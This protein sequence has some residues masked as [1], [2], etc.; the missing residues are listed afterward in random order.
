MTT[1]AGL[2]VIIYHELMKWLFTNIIIIEDEEAS[3]INIIETDWDA[4][5]ND[6]REAMRLDALRKKFDKLTSDDKGS[7]N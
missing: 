1:V 4:I 3:E 6:A 5:D 2:A 7:V